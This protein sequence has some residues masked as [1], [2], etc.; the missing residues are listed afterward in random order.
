[1]R[2][3]FLVKL[4]TCTTF[5]EKFVLFLNYSTK[6]AKS[7]LLCHEKILLHQNKTQ[8]IRHFLHAN[9]YDIIE[10]LNGLFKVFFGNI[11]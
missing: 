8:V 10:R 6:V 2:Y 1:M 5:N 9:T 3:K 4:D 11:T 7:K